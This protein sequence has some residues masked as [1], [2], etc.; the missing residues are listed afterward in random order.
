MS[1]LRVTT[2]HTIPKLNVFASPSDQRQNLVEAFVED[3]STRKSLQVSG[4]R[5]YS[6]S[7]TQ[8]S[9]SSFNQADC[10]RPMPDFTRITKRFTRGN[11]SL[12]DVVRVYQA[13]AKV[14]CSVRGNCEPN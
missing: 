7:I 6:E 4:Q 9:T 14:Y 3:A 13:V 12:E 2:N 10:L 8:S 1:G 5:Y 11:A